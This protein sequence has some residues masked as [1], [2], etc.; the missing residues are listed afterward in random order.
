M[1]SISGILHNSETLDMATA[2]SQKCCEELVAADAVDILLKQIRSASRSIP[3]QEVLKHALSTL[4]NLTRYQH[5]TEVLIDTPGSVEIILWELHRNKE[6][7]FIASEILKKICSN[8]KGVKAV[9][10]F[11]ALLKRL[12]DLV[13]ELTRKANIEKRNPRAVVVRENADRRL[14]EAI[15]LLKLTTNG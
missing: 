7:Y 13:E 3:Y 4:R 1:K 6:G 12:H 10:R 15:E 5:L 2:H 11:P 8:Q 9:H 14:R